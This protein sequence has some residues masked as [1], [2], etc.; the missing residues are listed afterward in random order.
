M[1]GYPEELGNANSTLA[2]KYKNGESYMVD[3]L[4]VV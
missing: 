3:K 4:D 2:A 1:H